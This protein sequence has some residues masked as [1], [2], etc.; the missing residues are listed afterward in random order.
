KLE[1]DDNPVTRW[2]FDNAMKIE[3]RDQRMTI[4]KPDGASEKKVDGIISAAM[5]LMEM[6]SVEQPDAEAGSIDVW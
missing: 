3:D 1:L 6:L 5:A 4:K 2:M